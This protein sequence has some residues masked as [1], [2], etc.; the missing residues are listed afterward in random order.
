MN[1]PAGVATELQR[2]FDRRAMD[3]ESIGF[4]YFDRHAGLANGE[5]FICNA[6]KKEFEALGLKTK[7]LGGAAYS[8]R[9]A[10]F[11]EAK[12]L[13]PV[14]ALRTELQELGIDCKVAEPVK[15]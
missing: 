11:P 14:F 13:H 6:G 5:V 1:E 9:G 10:Q 8:F 15:A 4:C 3:R 7:R 2:I 12:Q